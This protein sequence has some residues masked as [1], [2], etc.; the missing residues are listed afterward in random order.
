MSECDPHDWVVQDGSDVAICSKCG[1][2]AFIG[3]KPYQ[4]PEPNFKGP[5]TEIKKI[6]YYTTENIKDAWVMAKE[7]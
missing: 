5:Y 7:H 2:G 1:E 6:I 4:S 3:L